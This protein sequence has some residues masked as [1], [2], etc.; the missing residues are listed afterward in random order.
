MVE[1]GKDR[2]GEKG[3]IYFERGSHYRVSVKPGTREISKSS[4]G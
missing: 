3:K 4:P 2:K 1:W